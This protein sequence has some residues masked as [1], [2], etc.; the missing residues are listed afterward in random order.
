MNKIIE[1]STPRMIGSARGLESGRTAERNGRV[2]R[3]RLLGMSSAS[4]RLVLVRLPLDSTNLP[5]R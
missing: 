2:G 5:N 4:R 1:P 3:K